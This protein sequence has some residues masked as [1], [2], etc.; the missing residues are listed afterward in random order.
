MGS[1]F[2]IEKAAVGN[3]ISL[4]NL[5]KEEIRKVVSGRELCKIE[6]KERKG[7]L[8]SYKTNDVETESGK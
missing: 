4:G 5:Q 3:T 1:L 7:G 8:K 2:D 6:S